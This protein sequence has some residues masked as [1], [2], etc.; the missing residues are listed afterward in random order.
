VTWTLRTSPIAIP[1]ITIIWGG[2]QFVAV[3]V[4]ISGAINVITSPDGINWTAQTTVAGAWAVLMYSP[5]Y[6]RYVAMAYGGNVMYS[7]DA[8]TWT[9]IPSPI[10][11]NNW[12]AGAWSSEFGLFVAVAQGGVH[13]IATSIDGIS[14]NVYATPEVNTWLGIAWAPQMGIF[15]VVGQTGTHRALVSRYVKKLIA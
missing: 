8:I 7:Y 12:Y 9:A 15:S 10:E 14:W 11:A 3:G 5:D 6:G 2:G 4:P 13:Q 1:W